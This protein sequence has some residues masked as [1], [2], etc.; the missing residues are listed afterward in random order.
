MLRPTKYVIVITTEPDGQLDL[1][2]PHLEAFGIETVVLDPMR[3]LDGGTISF[4]TGPNGRGVWLGNRLL[5]PDP[6]RT[7]IWYG[8]PFDVTSLEIDSDISGYAHAQLKLHWRSLYQAFRGAFWV[9]NP[10]A[11]MEA[12][13]KPEQQRL[14][15]Q[16]GFTVV[17][18]LQTSDPDEAAR[19]V[20]RQWD[21]HGVCAA[22]LLEALPLQ[23]SGGPRLLPRTRLLRPDT[24]GTGGFNVTTIP[25]TFQE[26]VPGIDIRVSV[27][28]RKVF[29]VELIDD[30]AGEHP[31][32]IDWRAAVASGSL[33][34]VPHRLP[35]RIARRC[36]R[37]VKQLGLHQGMID[38]RL[39]P[40]GTYVFLEI[41]PGGLWGFIHEGGHLPIA[42]AMARLLRHRR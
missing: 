2:L 30:R 38:L 18:T 22:K 15:E 13:D 17:D 40:D 41:N 39:R 9:S 32:I 25:V 5:A 10:Y 35:R 11:I 14:A 23:L 3:L 16:L 33:R 8:H 4:A 7:A 12:S 34:I 19:F 29:T 37:L 31:D 36:R 28:G 21:L 1:V 24:H 27:I 42:Q 26:F 20:Q 6:S